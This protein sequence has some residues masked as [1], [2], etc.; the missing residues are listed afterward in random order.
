MARGVTVGIFDSGARAHAIWEAYA[1]DS[2]VKKGVIAPGN[3]FIQYT[4]TKEV[5]LV[6][7]CDL[8]NPQSIIAVAEEFG[9]DYVDIAQDDAVASGAGDILRER[10]F[11]VIC[12]ANNA[13]YLES[14]KDLARLFMVR[15][16]IPVP[17]FIICNSADDGRGVIDELY[18][19]NPE[20]ELYIKAA[21]LCAGKGALKAKNREEAHQR[22]YEMQRFE[23]AGKIFL[24]ERALKGSEFSYTVITDGLIYRTFKIA[25]DHKLSGTFN[26]G[27]QTGGMGANAPITIEDKGV[28]KDIERYFAQVPIKG[29]QREDTSFAGI[30]YGGG[31]LVADPLNPLRVSPFNIEFNARFGDPEAQVIL[32][33]VENYFEL[34]D[35]V[36]RRRLAKVKII[37]DRKY[38]VGIVGASR[39]YPRDYCSV[40]GKQIFG[41]ETAMQT[42][43]VKVY[44]AAIRIEDGK[45]FAEGGRL[46]TIVGEGDDINMAIRRAGAAMAGVYI[47][48]NNLF[49]RTDIG[50]ED[51]E[52]FF[53]RL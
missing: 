47:E 24:I 10:G 35:A 43:G 34:A 3:D 52:N 25:C 17:P 12:P 44:G 9:L 19:A 8:K 31:M 23:E 22:I 5:V 36:I 53:R 20:A 41:L 49:W 40:R 32:P 33:G 15:N 14:R 6:K 7:E 4:S 27:E 46:F 11:K 38:R 16:G 26:E 37:D 50:W 2:H 1:K 48:G 28:Y 30:L 42:E 45:F 39:G 18:E 29:M 21:G 13:S 51:R